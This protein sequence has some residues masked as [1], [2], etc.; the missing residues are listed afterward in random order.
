LLQ[1]SEFFLFQLHSATGHVVGMKMSLEL[2]PRNRVNICVGIAVRLPPICCY[3]KEL[4]RGKKNFLMICALGDHELLLDSFEPILDFHGVFCLRES[5]GAS[6]QELSQ[7][8]LMRWWCLLLMSL[9]VRI[10]VVEGLQYNLHQLVQSGNQLLNV[11]GVV[12]GGG[13]VAGLAIAL[14]I[15]YVHHPNVS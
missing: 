5:S 10:H 11:D 8:R 9:R 12:V 7:T 13:G 6:L 1:V 3:S 4:V 15:P 2:I 14:A